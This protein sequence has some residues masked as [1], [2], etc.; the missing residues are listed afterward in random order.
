MLQAALLQMLISL[1]SSRLLYSPETERLSLNLLPPQRVQ[2]C[3]PPPNN[4]LPAEH[5]PL[6]PPKRQQSF[7]QAAHPIRLA[8]Q[9]KW[10]H[11]PI[12]SLLSHP[13][14]KYRL[15]Q[16]NP[17]IYHLKCPSSIRAVPT[18]GLYQ[19]PPEQDKN[20]ILLEGKS[21]PVLL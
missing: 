2:N 16:H 19:L 21:I 11:R 3:L 1:L 8:Q 9:E 17:P 18:Q 10:R 13:H 7:L 12:N 20:R 4:L 15:R 14:K 5:L 6:N